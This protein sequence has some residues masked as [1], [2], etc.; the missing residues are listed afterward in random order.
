MN[1][2]F[3]IYMKFINESVDRY[4][5][6]SLGFYDFYNVPIISVPH[7]KFNFRNSLDTFLFF[8]YSH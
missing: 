5:S 7:P 8:F 4:D 3:V 2:F 6:S 1:V